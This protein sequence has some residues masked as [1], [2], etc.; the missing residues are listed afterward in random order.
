MVCVE[1]V[2]GAPVLVALGCAAVAVGVIVTPGVAAAVSLGRLPAAGV[3]EV[4]TAGAA[5]TRV[6]GA[7]SELRGGMPFGGEGCTASAAGL[8]VGGVVA[9]S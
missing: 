1:A 9:A 4:A 6:M 5:W 7:S 8:E 3:G 2:V